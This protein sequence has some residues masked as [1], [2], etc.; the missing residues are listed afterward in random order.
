VK[1]N[2]GCGNYR[3]DGWIN[4]DRESALKPHQI[5]DLERTPWPWADCSVEKIRLIHLPERVV[6]PGAG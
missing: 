1:L 6:K 2:L 5:W 3:L 4:V